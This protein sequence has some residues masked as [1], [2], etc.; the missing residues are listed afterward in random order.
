MM[1]GTEKCCLVW[2]KIDLYKTITQL[3]GLG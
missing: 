1:K 3:K 2:I